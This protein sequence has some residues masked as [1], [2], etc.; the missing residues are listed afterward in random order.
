MNGESYQ[1]VLNQINEDLNQLYTPNQRIFLSLQQDGATILYSTRDCA[2]FCP[3]C[4]K[5]EGGACMQS[6]NG[7]HTVEVL[8]LL[9]SFYGALLKEKCTKKSLALLDSWNEL[10]KH[11]LRVFRQTHV[12]FPTDICGRVIEKFASVPAK[13]EMGPILKV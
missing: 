12:V 9:T 11:S 5:T 7:L 2:S 3:H 13:T 6:S 8:G 1:K 10:L 4:L